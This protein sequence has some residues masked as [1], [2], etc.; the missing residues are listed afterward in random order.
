MQFTIINCS[1][2][3]IP[4]FILLI[5]FSSKSYSDLNINGD[6]SNQFNDRHISWSPLKP[7]RAP[8]DTAT[9]LNKPSLYA[10]Q[11]FVALNWPAINNKCKPNKIMSLGDEGA[12]VWESW[13]SREQIF[14]EGAQNPGNWKNVCKD[15]QLALPAGNFS[16]FED[17]TV[18]V[19]RST[20][21]YILKNK[22]YSLDEQ[23][24]LASA[25]VRNLDFPLGSKEI[26]A[27]WVRI[28][29][30]DKPRY[31]WVETERDGELVA[32]GLS[33]LHIVSKD[34]PNWFWSTFEHVDNDLRWPNIYPNAFR[35]W[36]YPSADEAACPADHLDWNQIPEGFG[37]EGTK[38]E[39]YR[40]RGTQTDW[41]DSRGN[42][43]V[44]VNSQLESFI[45][46]TSSSCL[47]CHALAVKGTQGGSMPIIPETGEFT[48]QGLGIGYIGVPDAKLFLDE[49]GVEIPYLGLDYVW[50]L[51]HAKRELNIN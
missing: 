42:P 10:W 2:I 40:L 22:L 17:E 49:N 20:Y 47:T 31:H 14:L 27:H 3:F 43:T 4:L 24:R 39:N 15:R 18:R 13:P 45:D 36:V 46:Q 30:I 1:K 48:D 7:W 44:G 26:K 25:G 33:G 32:Y 16:G 5:I 34:S 50:V 38:W 51:R 8:K 37:L 9:A 23:E 19:N 6:L 11:L 35:G 29:E 41:V 28:H 21:H 12:T